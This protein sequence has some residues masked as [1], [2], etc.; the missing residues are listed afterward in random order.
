MQ[1]GWASPELESSPPRELA[2]DIL[3]CGWE[4]DVVREL[5]PGACDTRT[6]ISCCCV[7][8]QSERGRVVKPV[9]KEGT[10]IGKT[11]RHSTRNS[12]KR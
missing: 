11:F 8:Q 2:G 5:E 4:Y 9:A 7:C 1:P 12:L 3:C 6:G 10:L